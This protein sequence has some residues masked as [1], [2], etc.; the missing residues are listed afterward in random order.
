MWNNSTAAPGA[1]GAARVS[2]VVSPRTAVEPK[3]RNERII[4]SGPAPWTTETADA[5]P[6][7]GLGRL[8]AG[9]V[10]SGT[11]RPRGGPRPSRTGN[12]ADR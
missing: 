11:E 5:F 1:G 4:E 7:A 2:K 12:A 10:A 9:L 3:L 6:A 8:T